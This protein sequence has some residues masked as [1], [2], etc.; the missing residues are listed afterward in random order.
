MVEEGGKC[1]LEEAKEWIDLYFYKY[2]EH[3]YLMTKP[4][5]S[6][7]SILSH[8]KIWYSVAIAKSWHLTYSDD[9]LLI[10]L[11]KLFT[12]SVVAH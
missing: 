4:T 12:I 6:H 8:W 11:Q 9:P 7:F 1:A 3:I 2:E 10:W 5:K